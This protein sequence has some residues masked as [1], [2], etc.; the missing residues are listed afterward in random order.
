MNP[1]SSLLSDADFGHLSAMLWFL[2]S[3]LL[4]GPESGL[5]V[6]EGAQNHQTPRVES[7][8]QRR[9]RWFMSDSW[10]LECLAMIVSILA[11]IS[12]GVMLGLY[13]GKPLS[14]WSHTI[15]LNTALSTLATVMKGFM[16]IPIGS[17]LSQ[18]KWHWY[19]KKKRALHDFGIF[20]QA[21]RG[22]WGSMMLLIRLK[23]WHFASIGALITVLTL[24]SDSFVQQS[25]GYPLL[26]VPQVHQA[27]LVPYAQAYTSYL[28]GTYG[29]ANAEVTQPMMAAIY[30]GVFNSNLTRS[31]SSIQATC[32]SGN[33]TYPAYASLAVCSHCTEV[34]SMLQYSET[35]N[36]L[37]TIYTWR[38]PNGHELVNAETA[39][40]QINMTG[41][42]LGDG[43]DSIQTFP[44]NSKVLDT[45]QSIGTLTNISIIAESDHPQEPKNN[46]VAIDCTLHFCAKSYQS[47]ALLNIYDENV[48]ITYDK[49]R[50]TDF[51]ADRS[52]HFVETAQFSVPSSVF[53][54]VVHQ[55][56]LFKINISGAAIALQRALALLTGTVMNTSGAQQ[57]FTTSVAQG[58]YYRGL[59]VSNM[60][61]TVATIALALS[62][63]IRQL[64]QQK[65]AGSDAGSTPGLTARG[66]TWAL[67]SHI[68]VQWL[69]LLLPLFMVL[70]AT[71]FLALTIWKASKSG[72]PSWRSSALAVM[73][74]GLNT[75]MLEAGSDVEKVDVAGVGDGKESVG[76]L[77]S[78]AK[79]MDVRL[80][81]RGRSACGFGLGVA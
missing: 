28:D 50:W 12:I 16:M 11:L 78:W 61:N 40:T 45:Y 33:C 64:R 34:T 30:D 65:S 29:I 75:T 43:T 39:I 67:L 38:L 66:T 62:N 79:G 53:P 69:W 18:L 2:R 80:Q 17:C 24:A 31:A 10:M 22:P 26:K 73:E 5:L 81:R 20:D 58:F 35:P 27:A 52:N 6:E 7:K 76:E 48:S 47:S 77:E 13:N 15:S 14:A 57:V 74:H 51:A 63:T 56:L 3:N 49:P 1:R 60:N 8:H 71:A 23:F 54:D 68:E 36:L 42:S 46:A 32:P 70:L 44:L 59:Q 37:G 21:S 25:V 41:T 9:L 55:S 4:P 19:S 72:I